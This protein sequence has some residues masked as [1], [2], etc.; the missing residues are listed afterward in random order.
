MDY[1]PVITTDPGIILQPDYVPVMGIAIG[2]F[3]QWLTCQ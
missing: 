1:L 2:K 3:L